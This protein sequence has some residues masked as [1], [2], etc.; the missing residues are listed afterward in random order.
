MAVKLPEE[1]EVEYELQVEC[2]GQAVQAENMFSNDSWST[3]A[4]LCLIRMDL[5]DLNMG[6]KA[7]CAL[8]REVLKHLLRLIV[9]SNLLTIGRKIIEAQATT[10][11]PQTTDE[12][13][14]IA[15]NRTDTT[16]QKNP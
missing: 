5:G 11:G 16:K 15:R 2:Q 9:A 10:V 14:L 12:W 6:Q 8:E 1:V 4:D 3:S 7:A 13:V